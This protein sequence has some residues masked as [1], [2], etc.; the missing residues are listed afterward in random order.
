[1]RENRPSGSMRG[2]VGRSLALGLFNQSAP[3]TILN[4]GWDHP[5]L[6]RLL[7]FLHVHVHPT[8]KVRVLAFSI[9]RRLESPCLEV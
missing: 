7:A 6:L 8:D 4:A 3:P 1:M 2:G 9:F 5:Y